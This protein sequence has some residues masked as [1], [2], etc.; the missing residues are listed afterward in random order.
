MVPPLQMRINNGLF[1][2]LYGSRKGLFDL[3]GMVESSQE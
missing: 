3:E 2:P 1:N